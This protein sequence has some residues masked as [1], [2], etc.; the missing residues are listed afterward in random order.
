MHGCVEN[1]RCQGERAPITGQVAAAGEGATK[2]LVKF[3]TAN[4]M[5]ESNIGTFHRARGESLSRISL[6]SIL[7]RK[8]QYLFRAINILTSQDIVKT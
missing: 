5:S 8:N 3:V 2:R 7:R 6:G 1:T 4:T